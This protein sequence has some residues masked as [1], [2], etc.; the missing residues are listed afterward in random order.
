[1]T[2]TTSQLGTLGT[3]RAT[4]LD[5]RNYLTT[6]SLACL[7]ISRA[8]IDGHYEGEYFQKVVDD[9]FSPDSPGSVR[10]FRAVIQ[11]LNKE[12]AEN[13]RKRAPKYYI[14]SPAK[15]VKGPRSDTRPHA[16]NLPIVLSREEALD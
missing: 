14:T 5:C 10:R 6:L 12:W 4:A 7:D 2:D 8:A 16:S 15:D 13:V 1:M 11:Y 9:L 3:R